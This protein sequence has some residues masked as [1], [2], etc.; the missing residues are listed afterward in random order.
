[1]KEF[2]VPIV[3]LF[4]LSESQKKH[5][6]NYLR[7][8]PT[9]DNSQHWKFH[10]EN[11]NLKIYLDEERSKHNLNIS[12][13]ASTLALGCLIETAKIW[14]DI[15]SFNMHYSVAN[16]K[17]FPQLVCLNFSSGNTES[18]FEEWDLFNRHTNRK[19]FRSSNIPQQLFAELEDINSD[20]DVKIH[21]NTEPSNSLRDLYQLGE[22][23]IWE[24]R[25]AF[26]DT[27]D[28]VRFN[29]S[30][31]IRTL[32]GFS[33]KNLNL[34]KMDGFI[35]KLLR[36]SY[37]LQKIFWYLGAGLKIKLDTYRLKKNMGGVL[38]IS[39]ELKGKHALIESG[40]A[41]MRSWIYLNKNS[42]S[43]QPMTVISLLPFMHSQIGKWPEGTPKNFGEK[44]NEAF[45]AWN[46]NI[47]LPKTH[48]ITWAI[49]FGYAQAMKE[50][51][52]TYRRQS[53]KF[54]I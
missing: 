1:M 41:M 2:K 11:N 10:F 15:N 49:R 5:L 31:C 46:E 38:A 4:Q 3:N 24:N 36:S 29:L 47:D 6:I 44:I 14:A 7:F 9:G 40:R 42:I 30:E 19:F 48:K 21:Y 23:F 53:E 16:P 32:D 13:S 22:Y 54:I 33:L 51:E 20:L 8:S 25:N 35:L 27:T 52:K 18:L 28:W 50:T 37:S 43:V 34:K 17:D 26:I 12:N 45:D 39:T